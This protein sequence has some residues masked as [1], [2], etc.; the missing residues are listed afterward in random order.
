M[1]AESLV[2]MMFRLNSGGT[3]AVSRSH[4][5]PHTATHHATMPR[6]L[7]QSPA[8]PAAFGKIGFRLTSGPI[9]TAIYW[10][11]AGIQSVLDLRGFGVCTMWISTKQE[12]QDRAERPSRNVLLKITVLVVQNRT[13][14]IAPQEM[15]Y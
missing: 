8:L 5:E 10:K 11:I 9:I 15:Y 14:P 3:V 4:T 13:E 2:L 7:R 6:E 12:G 1:A